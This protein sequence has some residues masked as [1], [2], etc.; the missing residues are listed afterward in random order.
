MKKPS[1]N[2]ISAVLAIAIGAFV[3]LYGVS[4]Y[5][6]GTIQRMGPGMVPVLF[7][8]ILSVLGAILLITEYFN[9]A[10]TE[11]PAIAWRPLIWVLTGVVAFALILPILGVVPATA[12]LI[13]ISSRADGALSIPQALGLAAAMAFLIWVVFGLGLNLPIPFLTWRL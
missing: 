1:A 12:F 9:S 6:L 7:G 3:V 8:A 5:R 10:R 11:L 13:L 2:T 4:T